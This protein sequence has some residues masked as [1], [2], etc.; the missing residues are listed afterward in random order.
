MQK[1]SFTNRERV[2]KS[3]KL[4]AKPEPATL[5]AIEEQGL[6]DISNEIKKRGERYKKYIDH[7][8]KN[9]I[10]RALENLSFDFQALYEVYTN[11]DE[12]KENKK[13]YEEKLT[14]LKKA[15]EKSVSNSLPKGISNVAGINSSSFLFKTIPELIS[16][17]D[18][19]EAEKS[20]C[21]ELAEGL[22]GC[23]ALLRKFCIS[24]ITAINTWMPERVIENF[25]IYASNMLHVKKFLESE[26][27][28]DFLIDFPELSSI[29]YADYYEFCVTAGEITGYNRLISGISNESGMVTK[30]YNAYINEVNTKNK[31]DKSYNGPFF[32]KLQTLNKQ[33]LMPVEKQFSIEKITSDD[34]VREILKDVE[35]KATKKDLYDIYMLIKSADKSGVVLNGKNLHTLSHAVYGD[36][37]VIPN[38]VIEVL[39]TELEEKIRGC[40]NTKEKA[41][42]KKE[43]DTLSTKI[44]NMF[45]T[46][47]EIE[48]YMND[49]AIFTA[50]VTA[51]F[52]KYTN[53][54]EARQTLVE[55]DI[56]K[57]RRIFRREKAKIIVKNSLDAVIEYRSFVNL[58]IPTKDTDKADNYF[59]NQL[60]EKCK[61]MICFTKATNLCR[62]YLS[63]KPKDIAQEEEFFFGQ[64][65]KL[66]SQWWKSAKPVFGAKESSILRKN[67]KYYI[68]TKSPVAKPV[69]VKLVKDSNYQLL[70]YKTFQAANK[71]FPMFTFTKDIKEAFE[72]TD[73]NECENHLAKGLIVTREQYNIYKN[74]SYSTD[75][76]RK[77]KISEEEY[78]HNLMIMI[79]LYKELAEKHEILKS[80]NLQFAETESY[81]DIGMFLDEVDRQ[82]TS[83]TWVNV[84]EETIDAA[85][86]EGALLSF[87]ITNRNM[88]SDDNVK[89]TY[90][91]TFLYL[92]S[93]ENMKNL[94][95][96]LNSNPKFSF[97]PACIP[98]EVTH[99]K[100]SML[101]NKKNIYGDP[102]RGDIYTELL[103][104][105]NGR[106]PESELSDEAFAQKGL[107]EV[108]P[109]GYDISKDYR[110]MVDKYFISMNYTLNYKVSDREKNTITEE[111]YEDMKS[112]FKTLSVAR[113]TT[114]LIYYTLF[115][116][117][118][119]EMMSKSLNVING[120]DYQKK[121]QILSDE[122]NAEKSN[123]WNYEKTVKD[124]KSSYINFAIAEILKVA[125]E[126]NAIIVIEKLDE[127]FKNKMCAIDNQVYKIFETKLENRLLDYRRKD[128]AS[129]EVG[130]ISKPM[131][132]GKSNGTK[133]MQ[134]GI[135]FHMN[136]AYTKNICPETGFVNLFNLSSTNTI[137]SQREFLEAFDTIEVHGD[138][139]CFHF[140][141]KNFKVNEKI[142]VKEL[143]KTNWTVIVGKPRTVFNR[144]V[145]AYEYVEYPAREF[146]CSL[147]GDTTIN[148]SDLD[149]KQVR[150]LFELFKTTIFYTTVKKCNKVSQEYYTSPVTEYDDT[151][152]TP[153]MVLTKMLA[154]KLWY[155]MSLADDFSGD[156]TTNWLNFAAK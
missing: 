74:K 39:S 58:I 65:L 14:E 98:Y 154:K 102:I 29:Q 110:Y 17:S 45:F 95:F 38:K 49:D 141:Y 146:I 19:S 59:Y 155:H 84:D 46:F 119:N 23:T 156:Y 93:D 85:I 34:E 71:S 143:N 40:E 50:Y 8:V 109:A 35:E 44:A 52:E 151:T 148:V 31:H 61:C 90:A 56:Y 123:N 105:F 142:K 43:L 91:R 13:L 57:N 36:H 28:N 130:S 125:T 32:K 37:N 103:N 137:S 145:K 20:E 9:I 16:S 117:N 1:T 73:V 129:G 25:E 78:R 70:S 116:E 24:R 12:S 77:K 144:E 120:F 106:I 88:Y 66:E 150:S 122:R 64:P 118:H 82:T 47:E 100:G 33:I 128:I 135:L 94:N 72:T 69:H 6:H 107:C 147:N 96:R 97:R 114:D 92:M 127:K 104:F 112:G 115:D 3:F 18:L 26:Y 63:S 124:I 41:S 76:L 68:V 55:E 152:M 67:N 79:D 62:N 48:E 27:A 22:T 113:G 134:N 132:L 121:L 111:V 139:I 53:V 4:E 7:E 133:S 138:L 5:K 10:N 108:H 83:A 60:D 87:L 51:L 101:L 131:Q 89:T 30:G 21:V 126:Y 153:S 11:S 99:A 54:L 2:T 42:Y 149:N 86:N 80:F 75:S 136:S 15:I 81:Q 140:D